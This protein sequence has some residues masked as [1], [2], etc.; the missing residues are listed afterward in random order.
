MW[1]NGILNSTGDKEKIYNTNN[2]YDNYISITTVRCGSAFGEIISVMFISN[3]KSINFIFS[4]YILRQNPLVYAMKVHR[5][6]TQTEL[7]LWK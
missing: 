6:M 2:I 3:A 7:W 4:Q 1:N 5:Q